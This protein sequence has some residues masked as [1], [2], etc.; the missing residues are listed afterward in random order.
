MQRT[1]GMRFFLVI[2]LILG[3]AFRFINLDSKVYWY[4]EAFTSLRVAGYTEAE[5]VQRFNDAGVLTVAE[6]QEYQ[7]FNPS[8]SGVDVVRSLVQEAPERPPLY[9]LL[10]WFWARSL[11]TGVI[12]MR[13]LAVVG[14]LLIFP[15]LYWLCQELFVQTKTLANNA[16]VGWV[17]MAML[18]ISPFHLLYAQEAQPYSFWTGLIVFCTAAL[19][20]AL[21]RQ[22]ATSWV[23]Y[24]I[25][26]SA[27]LYTSLVSVLLAI[28][29]LVYVLLVEKLRP[30]GRVLGFGL[31]SGLAGA[32]ASPWLWLA[33]TRMGEI[34]TRLG[35]TA[36]QGNRLDLPRLWLEQV[37]RLVVDTPFSWVN[38]GGHVLTVLVL[39]YS[40]YLLCRFTPVRVWGLVVSSLGV[41]AIVLLVPDLIQQTLR[42]TVPHFLFPALV[43][44]QLALAYGLTQSMTVPWKWVWMQKLGRAVAIALFTLSVISCSFLSPAESWWTKAYN[45]EILP[46]AAAVEQAQKNGQALI[47]SDARMGDL[48]AL[49]HH[50]P[51]RTAV[52]LRPRCETC[53]LEMTAEP[54]IPE[55]P[56]EYSEIFFYHPRA[57]AEW[58]QEFQ[59]EFEQNSRYRAEALPLPGI[60]FPAVWRIL[61]KA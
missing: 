31:A 59:Q 2:L 41:A 45:Q 4:H 1:V 25:A 3:I 36:Q 32:I 26:L 35:W 50:L 18:A 20:R 23:I 43:S 24:A 44:V 7:M 33:A 16:W 61:P 12:G 22:T 38:L 55:I 37:G 15:A 10:G 8:G 34:Q 27:S 58:L 54:V 28:A 52:L 47:V 51:L 29:H 11:D 9:F 40:L 30:T 48:L 42:S 56:A 57:D 21:R 17:A 13:G 14:S 53:Q 49:S 46:F 6:V 60:N 39:G 19:L 5:A